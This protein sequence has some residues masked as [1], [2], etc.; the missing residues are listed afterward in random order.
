MTGAEGSARRDLRNLEK[1]RGIFA[2][3]AKYINAKTIYSSNN[4]N[5]VNFANAFYQAFRTFFEDEKELVLSI[6]QYRIKWNG[7]VVYDNQEKTNSI[8]FLLF[9]DGVGEITFQSSV[10]PA[11]LERF[12]DLLKNEIYTPSTH[13][14]IVSRFWQSEFAGIS[15]RVFDECPDGAAGDG[16][17]AGS[18]SRE[19]P[20]QASDHPHFPVSVAATHGRTSPSGEPVGP[21]GAYLE[22][23]VERTHPGA[24]PLEKERHV[25]DLM[26]CL[27]TSSAEDLTSWRNEHARMID[28]N[29]LLQLL[30]IMLDF[31]QMRSAPPVV[32]D[33]SDIID[34]LVRYVA[35]EAHVPTLIALLEIQRTICRER[36]FAVEFQSLPSRIEHEITNSAFLVSL[37]RISD[38]SSANVYEVLRYFRMIGRN[39]VPGICELLATLKEPSLH[40]EACDALIGIAA[41]DIPRI[42][43]DLNLDNPHEAKDAIY[44][45]QRSTTN[46]V[47]PIIKKLVTSPEPHV[48]EHVIEYLVHVAN[49][50]AVTLLCALLEDHDPSV[51]MKTFVA[52][53]ELKHPLV[54][55]K[56]TDLCFAENNNSKSTDELDRMFRAL[57]KLGGDNVLES[58]GQM[59]HRGSWLGLGKSRGKQN[60]L[61]A[62]TAL[63]HIPGGQSLEMLRSLAR[64]GD[65]LVKTKALYVLK[66]LEQPKNPHAAELTT[67]SGEDAGL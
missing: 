13:L 36:P 55:G 7:E 6:E 59:I 43:N 31:A 21:L 52:V 28:E 30:A 33:I 51:R 20:L 16:R 35:E 45:L 34:R 18:A 60:K 64:D 47:H 38:R 44:L 40:K 42:V 26:V 19:Q 56:V 10:T 32:R 63:R 25:Q 67:V 3:L 2:S 1:V 11:E 54:I 22:S 23:L 48:R 58:I 27:F 5:V 53:E 57:G 62:I 39:A 15:Y 8:A 4:P 14:D 65:S 49:D 41:E 17:G 37:G 66:Q 46:E 24:T 9:K 29:K 12:V 61:L 50:E